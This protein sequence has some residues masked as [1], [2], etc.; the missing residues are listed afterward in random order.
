MRTLY[1][2]PLFA[3]LLFSFGLQAQQ[4]RVNQKKKLPRVDTPSVVLVPQSQKLRVDTNLLLPEDE[5]RRRRR[6]FKVMVV[7]AP[8]PGMTRQGILYSDSLGRR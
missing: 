8:P 2:I 1:R 5:R 6:G 7:P 4:R 3:L